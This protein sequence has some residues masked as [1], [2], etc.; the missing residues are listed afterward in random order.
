MIGP[1]KYD[2]ECT[3]VRMGTKAKGV[4]LIVIDGRLGSG[5]SV[6]ASSSAILGGLP[7]VL[8]DMAAQIRKDA[9]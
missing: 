4:V 5:F 1:G 8:E 2:D 3:M 7:D 6:Q 9:T